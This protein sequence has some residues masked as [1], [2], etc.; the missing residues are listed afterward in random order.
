M[1]DGCV[2]EVPFR[3]A[4]GLEGEI[5][6]AVGGVGTGLVIEEVGRPGAA[7]AGVRSL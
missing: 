2:V 6:S 7:G 3:M 4:L 5:W 1:V